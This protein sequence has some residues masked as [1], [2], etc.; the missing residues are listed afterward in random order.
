MQPRQAPAICVIGVT[1]FL[2]T[3]ARADDFAPP[4]WVRG[5]P[6]ST[7]AEWE[8]L[9]NANGHTGPDGTTVTTVGG[10]Y[11]TPTVSIYGN[12]GVIPAWQ[13]GDGDGEWAAP[14]TDPMASCRRNCESARWP[15]RRTTRRIPGS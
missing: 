8:F 9:T 14:D 11:G 5:A 15:R 12:P 10:T 13:L 4:P 1:A 2:A 6:L 7:A 3:L